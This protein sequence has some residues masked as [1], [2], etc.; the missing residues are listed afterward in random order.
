MGR[1]QRH[2]QSTHHTAAR[3]RDGVVSHVGGVA[4]A[5]ANPRATPRAVLLLVVARGRARAR[6]HLRERVGVDVSSID[7]DTGEED[8]DNTEDD[9]SRRTHIVT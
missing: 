6:R 3:A 4:H 2:S 7:D 5:C 8:D 1:G 9:T